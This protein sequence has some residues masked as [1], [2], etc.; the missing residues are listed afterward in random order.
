MFLSAGISI[1][2]RS[3]GIAKVE[4]FFQGTKENSRTGADTKKNCHSS[5]LL[6][7]S[8]LAVRNDD[9][10]NVI[11]GEA[12]RRRRDIIIAPCVSAG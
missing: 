5:G 2:V 10:V 4:I 11:A 12:K 7:G 6:H 9:A 3:F 8:F 1:W